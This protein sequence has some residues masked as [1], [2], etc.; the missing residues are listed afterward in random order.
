MTTTDI[1]CRA[2]KRI[3]DRVLG[4]LA[5]SPVVALG[6]AIYVVPICYAQSGPG[7]AA[8]SPPGFDELGSCTDLVSLTGDETL[9]LFEDHSVEL[10]PDAHDVNSKAI[11]GTWSYDESAKTYAVSLG[12]VMST[13]TAYSPE[14]LTVCLF[15][16]GGLDAGNLRES[17]ISTVVPSDQGEDKPRQR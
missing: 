15:V 13:Y 9:S 16:K 3:L 10:D 2:I 1:I 17:W 12:G 6:L 7:Q 8:P 11:E 4:A 14:A 5:L